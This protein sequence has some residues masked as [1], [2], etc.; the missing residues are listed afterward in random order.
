MSKRKDGICPK[1]GTLPKRQGQAYCRP[2]ANAYRRDYYRRGGERT[3]KA[4]RDLGRSVASKW[5]NYRS[6]A[7]KRG[8]SFELERPSFVALIR[9]DCH[10]CG[11]PGGG[12]DRVDSGEGYTER[13]AVACCGWCNRMKNKYAAGDWVDRCSLIAARWDG[14][15]SDLLRS[16]H[17]QSSETGE[18]AQRGGVQM[19]LLGWGRK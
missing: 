16:G 13:N 17:G 7:R 18:Q 11:G 8:L 19:S 4:S 10:W 15:S 6:G 12:V 3:R 2:C 1:C 14:R 5:S 9:A